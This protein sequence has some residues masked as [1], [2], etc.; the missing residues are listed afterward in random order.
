MTKASIIAFLLTPTL[1]AS[2]FI[3]LA[4]CEDPNGKGFVISEAEPCTPAFWSYLATVLFWCG[5]G[6]FLVGLV[7]IKQSRKLRE[8]SL[9]NNEKQK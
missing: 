1:I 3:I 8:F 6:S 9:L 7:F 4:T 2:A 5:V